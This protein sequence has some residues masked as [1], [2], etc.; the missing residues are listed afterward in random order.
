MGVNMDSMYLENLD[1]FVN[2]ESRIVTYKWLSLTLGVHTNV[3]KQMLYHFVTSQRDADKGDGLNVTYVVSGIVGDE[4]DTPDVHKVVLAREENL[5]TVKAK[6]KEIISV[7]IYSVQKTKLNDMSV[8]YTANYDKVK[9][10]IMNICRYSGIECSEAKVHSTADLAKREQQNAYHAPHDPTKTESKKKPSQMKMSIKKES[11]SENDVKQTIGSSKPTGKNNQI[12]SMFARQ[13]KTADDK[14]EGT[15]PEKAGRPNMGESKK[16]SSSSAKFKPKGNISNFFNKCPPV[17]KPQTPDSTKPTSEKPLSPTTGSDK[18]EST[19]SSPIITESCSPSS[20]NI[21]S[22]E[23]SKDSQ[24]VSK[25]VHSSPKK[26]KTKA[27]SQTKIA[28]KAKGKNKRKQGKGDQE[29][30]MKRKRI[31]QLSDSESSSD[32]ENEEEAAFCPSPPPPEPVC[33]ESDEEIPATPQ[34]DSLDLVNNGGRAKKRKLVNETYAGEGGF[35]VT[36]KKYKCIEVSDEEDVTSPKKENA[37][38]ETKTETSPETEMNTSP[39]LIG[40]LPQS[41][42]KTSRNKTT[43]SKKKPHDLDTKK[44]QSSIMSF[45]S[46]S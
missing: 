21:E 6:L 4:G 23:S 35:L 13:V 38:L 9:E 29:P 19:I 1:E 7:H 16:T 24:V 31:M 34:P 18:S 11:T 33:V 8:L 45:F 5:A 40:D 25:E 10:N 14:E 26:A 2:D 32:E 46:K 12:A 39:K 28:S 36:I 15:K 20:I 22:Q 37:S 30:K 27:K 44:K 42:T 17:K 43:K 41:K 3:A